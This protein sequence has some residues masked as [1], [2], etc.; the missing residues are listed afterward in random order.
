MAVSHMMLVFAQAP[1][2][3]SLTAS[4]FCL[5]NALPVPEKIADITEMDV[6]WFHMMYGDIQRAKEIADELQE[7]WPFEQAVPDAK[8]LNAYQRENPGAVRGA[9]KVMRQGSLSP[10]MWKKDKWGASTDITPSR[11]EV[12]DSGE[13]AIV[14]FDD[15]IDRT[16]ALVD[17]ACKNSNWTV[18]GVVVN[19]DCATQLWFKRENEK[20]NI[21]RSSTKDEEGFPKATWLEELP[22]SIASYVS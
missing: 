19:H 7:P 22:A 11:W 12:D 3:A 18:A 21:V 10:S 20:L 1:V 9:A 4:P 8:T 14:R 5:K 2:I 16:T 13:C 15:S 17:F 6:I